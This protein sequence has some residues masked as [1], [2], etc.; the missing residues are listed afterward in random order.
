M[1]GDVLSG[2]GL[3]SSGQAFDA[4]I[5]LPV[6][7]LV[8][9]LIMVGPDPKVLA[10][11]LG[12]AACLL[13]FRRAMLGWRG[14]LV[15]LC[16]VIMLVPARRYALPF[17][18][19]YK[20]EPYRVVVIFILLGVFVSVLVDPDFRL[21]RLGFGGVI[22]ALLGTSLLSVAGNV[23]QIASEGLDDKVV[24]GVFQLLTLIAVFVVA[25]LLIRSR[26]DLHLVLG[27]L[28]MCGAFVALASVV[29]QHTQVNIFRSFDS[30]SPFREVAEEEAGTL[31]GESFRAFGSAQHPIALGVEMALLIPIGIYLSRRSEW[32]RKS[33]GRRAVWLG[34]TVLILMGMVASV[35]RTTV[36]MLAC[37]LVVALLLRRRVV[38]AALPLAVPLVVLLVVV[39]PSAIGDLVDSLTPEGGLAAEQ[40]S[41]QGGRHSGRLADLGPSLEAIGDK[42]L[43]GEGFGT[44][45]TED[46]KSED[47]ILDNAYLTRAVDTGVP[48]LLGLVAL[49]VAPIRRMWR[50]ARDPAGIAPPATTDLAAALTCSFVAY[51]VSLFFYDGLA[52]FQPLLTFMIFLAGAAWLM[53]DSPPW[54]KAAPPGYVPVRV[55]VV[56]D[57]NKQPAL[58]ELTA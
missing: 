10:P 47:L 28:V 22:A 34:A 2:P 33:G 7:A 48:G 53:L 44:R 13:A 23:S 52:F 15:A 12:L 49:L 46:V 35:S 51:A 54:W 58:A 19:P 42:P 39:I 43:F 16:L 17:D 25:R 14:M 31:R 38:A 29:E 27:V 30:F 4:K 21:R 55:A 1:T 3:H 24:G 6:A 8:L 57:E 11:G 50:L 18:L 41:G 45:I 9:L 20:L 40:R 56:R 5:A 26:R 32:P 37:I 36:V